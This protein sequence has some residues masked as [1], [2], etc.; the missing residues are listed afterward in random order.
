MFLVYKNKKKKKKKN[1]RTKER[2]N[3]REKYRQTNKKK[4]KNQIKRNKICSFFSFS[5]YQGKQ[6]MIL[7]FKA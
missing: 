5:F 7:V 1:E 6:L 4:R 2:K 3:W